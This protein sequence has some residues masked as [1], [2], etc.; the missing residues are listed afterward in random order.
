M[1]NEK[2]T[3]IAV[4]A[5]FL[6]PPVLLLVILWLCSRRHPVAAPHGAYRRCFTSRTR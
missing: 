3:R 1:D 4:I 5:A 2:L 6:L